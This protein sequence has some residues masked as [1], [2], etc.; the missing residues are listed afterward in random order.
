MLGYPNSGRAS[1]GGEQVCLVEGRGGGHR[2]Q[3]EGP[4]HHRYEWKNAT[5]NHINDENDK[6]LYCITS[7]II[8]GYFRILTFYP[9]RII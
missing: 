5:A 4:D 9:R 6:L 1:Q 3:H 2:G 7:V 8:W